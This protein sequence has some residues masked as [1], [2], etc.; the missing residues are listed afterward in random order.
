M[1]HTLQGLRTI[2]YPVLDLQRARSWWSDFLGFAPYFDEPFYVGFNVGGYE[3]GLVPDGNPPSGSTTYWAVD[4]VGSAI[5]HAQSLGAEVREAAHD[6]GD[7]IV[8]GSI[9]TSD[10]HVV[11]FVFNPHFE[12]AP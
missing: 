3:L 7:G 6:V 11:G 5:A 2:V 9:T 8:L 4:D 12:P 1:S 10:A